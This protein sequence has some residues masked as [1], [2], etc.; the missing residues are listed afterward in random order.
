MIERGDRARFA[1]E[2]ETGVGT[3]ELQH[4]QRDVAFEPG[5]MGA[6]YLTHAAAAEQR[7]DIICAKPAPESQ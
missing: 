7:Q 1:F 6:V 3:V 5:I 4:L 2:P